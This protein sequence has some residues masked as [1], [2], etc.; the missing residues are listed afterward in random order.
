MRRRVITLLVGALFTLALVAP[1]V[2]GGW[3][4]T[5]V[6]GLPD[7]VVA[8]E[9]YDIGY[10]VRQHGDKPVDGLTTGIIVFPGDGESTVSFSGGSSIIQPSDGSKPIVFHNDAAEP[11]LSYGGDGPQPLFFKGEPSGAP[12]HYIAQVTLPEGGQWEWLVSQDIFGLAELGTLPVTEAAT[13][14]VTI[15]DIL[16]YTLPALAVVAVGLFVAQLVLLRDRKAAEPQ[17]DPVAGWQRP[18]AGD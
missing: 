2:A 13:T 18:V 16:K 10:T 8:G 1:A 4:V 11:F 14:G 5:S 7:E 17:A 3:A 12:G 15:T 6:D 9:T